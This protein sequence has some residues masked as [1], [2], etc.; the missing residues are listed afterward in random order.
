MSDTLGTDHHRA[1][2]AGVRAGFDDTT[3]SDQR[4]REFEFGVNEWSLGELCGSTLTY[5]NAIRAAKSKPK[6]LKRV[7]KDL[8]R[9][10]QLAATVLVALFATEITVYGFQS[11][12]II[13]NINTTALNSVALSGLTTAFG[14]LLLVWLSFRYTGVDIRVFNRRA[15]GFNGSYLFFSI[16]SRLP[17]L[18]TVISLLA[19]SVFTA[20]IIHEEWRITAIVFCAVPAILV[21]LEFILATIKWSAVTSHRAVISHYLGDPDDVQSPRHFYLSFWLVWFRAWLFFFFTMGAQASRLGRHAVAVPGDENDPLGILDQME[22]AFSTWMPW[23]VIVA[24]GFCACS[25]T[26]FVLE[27]FQMTINTAYSPNGDRNGNPFWPAFRSIIARNAENWRLSVLGHTRKLY[28]TLFWLFALYDLCFAI[29]TLLVLTRIQKLKTSKPVAIPTLYLVAQLVVHVV[30]IG[31]AQV[32]G[33]RAD[34]EEKRRRI[35]IRRAM[36]PMSENPFHT[37]A[38][39]PSNQSAQRDVAIGG[40][41]S[42]LLQSRAL[43]LAPSRAPESRTRTL[44]DAV[45][46]TP[47]L[48]SAYVAQQSR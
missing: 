34:S 31:T 18:A 20:A 5:Y 47:V 14:L 46:P 41:P 6:L 38:E 35:Q 26:M 7:Q 44:W 29:W 45:T 40:S 36:N 28:F 30:L 23:I 13:L 37:T 1:G 25:G 9:E 15:R 3:A 21:T 24:M 48:P 32:L 39:E 11:S 12:G 10:W 43:T 22:D 17:V 2:S 42:M 4:I 33:R 8:Q 16:N 19:M 27:V